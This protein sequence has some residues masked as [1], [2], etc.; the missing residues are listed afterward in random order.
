MGYPWCGTTKG[1]VLGPFVKGQEH[2]P[3]EK[4][5]DL[6]TREGLLD[7][8]R[9]AESCL[10]NE[11][12]AAVAMEAEAKAK[13]AVAE[14]EEMLKIDGAIYRLVD[15]VNGGDPG[16]LAALMIDRVT[17]SHRTLQ[18]SFLSALKLFIERY[19]TLEKGMYVD[20]RNEHAYEWCKRV[21]AID[22]DLLGLRFP[23]I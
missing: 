7:R 5:V 17:R 11:A 12:L 8:L 2:M 22:P 1:R 10:G 19:G 3:S 9:D 6:N 13:Q 14:K 18:E 4:K 23:L 20:G 16:A 15:Y 21:R